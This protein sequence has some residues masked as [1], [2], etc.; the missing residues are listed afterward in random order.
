MALRFTSDKIRFKAG[1][2]YVA[3]LTGIRYNQKSLGMHGGGVA[4]QCGRHQLGSN[5][6]TVIFIT[7]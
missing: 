4:G 7:L 1:F 5:G 6:D 2:V 3:F